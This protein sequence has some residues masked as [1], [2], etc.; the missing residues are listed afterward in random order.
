EIIPGSRPTAAQMTGDAGL[1]SLEG[2]LARNDD[3]FKSRLIAQREQ[4]VQAQLA[5]LD[6]VQNSGS[7]SAV[8]DYFNTRMRQLEEQADALQEAA[9]RDARRAADEL[10][11]E[12]SANE[13]GAQARA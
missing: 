2:V 4:Q 11:P 10:G 3:Q 1:A 6:D 8:P 5:A 7:P 9:T 13:V 12:R